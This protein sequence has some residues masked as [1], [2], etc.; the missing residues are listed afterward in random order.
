MHS[1]MQ[2]SKAL[3]IAFYVRKIAIFN[4]NPDSDSEK[5]RMNEVVTFPGLS[6]LEK[7][8]EVV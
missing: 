6:E 4:P 7:G 8:T 3:I 5:C 1:F 2:N